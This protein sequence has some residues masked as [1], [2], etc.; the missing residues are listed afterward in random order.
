MQ[1]LSSLGRRPGGKDVAHFDDSLIRN[2]YRKA[3]LWSYVG[4]STNDIPT[5]LLPCI[6]RT[7]A[8]VKKESHTVRKGRMRDRDQE[9][10]ALAGNGMETTSK[11]WTDK[12]Y[13][14]RRSAQLYRVRAF[15][16]CKS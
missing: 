5:A 4:D 14:A 7:A 13:R 16:I 3:F 11:Q 15:S 10:S 9:G 2:C 1:D 8:W 12:V 6:H